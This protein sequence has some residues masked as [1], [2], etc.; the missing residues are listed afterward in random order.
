MLQEKVK[1]DLDGALKSGDK[2]KVS[3]LRMLW[4]SIQDKEKKKKYELSL[5]N[6]E[7]FLSDQEVIDTISFEAKKRRESIKEFRGGQ[8]ED[9]AVKEEVELGILSVYLPEPLGEEDLV[10]M[11]EE[12]IKE[13]GAKDKK[14]LGKVMSLVMPK[15]KGQA[16]GSDVIRITK[17]LLF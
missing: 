10:K 9:L 11:I 6:E 3:V 2:E 15:V 13:I 14:E 4:A 12:V 5:N 17:N 16:D 7:V 1:K 8:R